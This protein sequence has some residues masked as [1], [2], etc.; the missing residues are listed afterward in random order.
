MLRFGR[1]SWLLLLTACARSVALD[2]GVDAAHDAAPAAPDCMRSTSALH[3]TRYDPGSSVIDDEHHEV[4]HLELTALADGTTEVDGTTIATAVL[5]Y[6]ETHADS[7]EIASRFSGD[8]ESPVTGG[9]ASTTSVRPYEYPTEYGSAALSGT[10]TLEPDG[11]VNVDVSVEPID[12][13]GSFYP[14]YPM[15]WQALACPR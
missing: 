1:L 4:L 15:S 8:A 9:Y 10:L 7:G 12:T 5:F 2:G 14:F 13:G 6:P 11:C 3:C